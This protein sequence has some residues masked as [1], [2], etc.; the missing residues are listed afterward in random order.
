[1][2]ISVGTQLGSYDITALIGE[3]GMGRVFRARDAKLK[4]DV[5][6][7]TLPEHFANDPERLARFQ[8]EAEALAAL[9]HPH[10][11]G[12]YDIAEFGSSRFLVLE[13]V[14]GE[15]LAESIRRGPIPLD[16]AL[17]IAAQ[18][19][20]ALEAAHEKGIVHRD[21][22]PANIKITPEGR[23]KVLDFGLAKVKEAGSAASSFSQSPTLLSATMPGVIL[24]TAAYMSPEQA[25][26]RD[27][28]RTSDV[29]AMGC[30]L[31]EMLVGKPAFEG[32]T[33]TEVLGGILKSEPDWTRLPAR[34]PEAI[35]KLLRRCLK[36]DRQW[37]LQHF[38]DVRIEIKDAQAEPEEQV[39]AAPTRIRER[40]FAISALLLAVTVIVL[41]SLSF[42][43]VPIPLETRLELTTPATKDLY[44]VALSPDGRNIAFVADSEGQSKLWLRSLDNGLAKPLAG[45][46]HPYYPFWSPD[47]RSIGFFADGKL[48]RVDISGGAVQALVDAPL[49]RGGAWN[50]DGVILFSGTAGAIFQI[51]STGGKPTAVTR[52]EQDH[53]NH[54]FPYFLSDGRHFLFLVTRKANA[55]DARGMYVGALDNTET[56][57]LAEVQA[58]AGLAPSGDLLFVRD[59]ALF[60]QKF[61]QN[62]YELSGSPL[63]VA[64]GVASDGGNGVSSV[65]ASRTG[66]LLYRLGAGGYSA[67][68]IWFD[69]SGKEIGGLTDAGS[70]LTNPEVSPDGRRL[71]VGRFDNNNGDVWL[72]DIARGIRTRFT[73]GAAPERAPVWAPDGSRIVFQSNQKGVDNLYIKQTGGIG[74]EEMLLESAQNKEPADWSRDGRYLLYH[75]DD[76]KT[77]ADLWALP[78]V[79]DRKPFPVAQGNSSELQG[80]FSPDGRWIAYESDESG[81][82]EIYVQPFPEPSRRWQ[83]SANGGTQPRWRADGKEIFFIGPN[84][85]MMASAII[86]NGAGIEPG[87]SVQLF[88]TQIPEGARTG[89]KQQY[90]VSAD[91]QRFL[92]RTAPQETVTSPLTLILNWTSP[93]K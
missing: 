79:G 82:F 91:G 1:M 54:R 5:A 70:S 32:E 42:R 83:I 87:A 55:S 65:S 59:G 69:R 43:P 39:P 28:D 35:R 90:V 13:L 24:G 18:I 15:T 52:L 37:R 75:T 22:K 88:T 78:L 93:A 46:E 77:G 31:Y 25:K 61:D 38:G 36:K 30:V 16:E 72:L 60:A 17:G 3:G 40:F 85:Q 64:E 6:I 44:S 8:R 67:Q 81:R 7:K 10:I 62:R 58:V 45:T 9:N 34:T 63:P 92:I 68:L 12:I 71:A 23:V 51:P 41:A 29:W 27:T 80:Q 49:G 50:S 33:I 56:H 2:P 86:V 66:S 48:K 53:S 20:E 11:A 76:S 57:Y 74:G 4:R 47:N 26:G 21:L 84:G 89:T 73:L 14:E 19:A